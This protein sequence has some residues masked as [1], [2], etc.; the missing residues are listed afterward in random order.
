MNETEITD[1]I[2]DLVAD[3][4]PLCEGKSVSVVIPASMNVVLVSIMS[5]A[6]THKE[7]ARTLFSGLEKMVLYIKSQLDA[8]APSTALH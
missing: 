8:A 4:F 7:D 5:V 6:D 2:N 3:M 1:E